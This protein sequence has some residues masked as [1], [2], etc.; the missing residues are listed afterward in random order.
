[1]IP[2]DIPID[3]RALHYAYQLTPQERKQKIYQVIPYSRELD[4]M[5]EFPEKPDKWENSDE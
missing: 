1:M 3:G 5:K 2:F 4:P